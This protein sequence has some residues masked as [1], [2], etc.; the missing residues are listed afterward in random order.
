MSGLHVYTETVSLSHF[1]TCNGI[2][3]VP[4]NMSNFEFVFAF[5]GERPS[6][7]CMEV[8]KLGSILKRLIIAEQKNYQS[9]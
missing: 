7:G 5:V 1:Y 6:T 2:N 9:F 3:F 4:G 8:A